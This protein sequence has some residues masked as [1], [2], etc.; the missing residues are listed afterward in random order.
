LKGKGSSNKVKT[1]LRLGDGAGFRELPRHLCR[2]YTS[3][4]PSLI[5]SRP[6]TQRTPA[7]HVSPLG[8][9]KNR[10]FTTFSNSGEKFSA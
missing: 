4:R 5:P 10:K 1:G 7:D 2:F 6:P 9:V 8:C 3:S